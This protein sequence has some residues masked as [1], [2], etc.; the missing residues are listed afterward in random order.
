MK[1]SNSIKIEFLPLVR[2]ARDASKRTDEKSFIFQEGFFLFFDCILS[3]VKF[4]C[5]LYYSGLVIFRFR[6]SSSCVLSTISSFSQI[7]VDH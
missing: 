6:A 5:Y 7:L 3:N 1:Y 4:I 2:S